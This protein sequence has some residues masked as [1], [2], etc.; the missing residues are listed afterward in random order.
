M[1]GDPKHFYQ[2]HVFVCT[3]ERPAGHPRGCCK[4]KGSEKLRDY[5]K[6]RAKELGL[7]ETRINSAGCL[8]RCEFGPALVIY[9]EGVWYRPET[10][11]DIDEILEVHMRQGKR[12]PRLMLKYEDRV[13]P[14]PKA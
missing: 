4:A 10:R 5:M 8:E 1:D 11:E 2:A 14:K 12:V 7:A 6:A 13:P 3:N 9:P